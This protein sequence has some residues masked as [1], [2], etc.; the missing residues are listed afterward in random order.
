MGCQAV[1]EDMRSSYPDLHV[2]SLLGARNPLFAGSP[3]KGTESVIQC[4]P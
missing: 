2:T 3:S 4:L 1:N